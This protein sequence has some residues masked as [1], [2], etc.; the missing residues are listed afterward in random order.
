MPS[1]AATSG[2]AI[3]SRTAA[4]QTYG[5]Q[6]TRIT[7]GARVRDPIVRASSPASPGVEFIFQLAATIMWCM[8]ESCQ[9]RGRSLPVQRE[10]LDPVERALD[11]AAVH[12][13]ALGEVGERRLRRLPSSLRHE[14]DHVRLRGQPAVGFDP[15]D[16]GELA[17][18]RR[19]GPLEVRRTPR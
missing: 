10:P 19:H 6:I 11:R 5:G 7:P 18:G 4:R 13:E 16:R 14:T 17:A 3:A 2:P 9:S 12:P 8:T 15:V 1:V